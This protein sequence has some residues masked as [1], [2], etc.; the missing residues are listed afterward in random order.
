MKIL[1]TAGPTREYI[2]PVRFI[3]NASSGKMGYELAKSAIKRKHNVILISGPTYLKPPAGVKFI[4]VTSTEEMYRKVMKHYPNVDAVIMSAA[5]TDY[6]P[7]KNYKTK[8]KKREK[9]TI[10][11]TKTPDILAEL[12]R[13]KKNQILIGF[14]LED[15]TPHKNAFEKFKKKNLDLIVLNSPEAIESDTSKAEIYTEH[16]GWISLPKTLKSNLSVKIIKLLEEM[17]K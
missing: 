15:K 6:R 14:A 4:R 11:L 8:L 7:K 13:R 3:S 16:T 5:V 1:I 12:G 17:K 2:D 10:E 9:L